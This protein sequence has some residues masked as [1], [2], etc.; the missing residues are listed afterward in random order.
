MTRAHVRLRAASVPLR[1]VEEVL[2]SAGSILDVGCGH[3]LLTLV[4]ALRCPQRTFL[5]VDVDEGKVLA[6]RAAARRLDVG[7]RVT[8]EVVPPTWLPEGRFDGLVAVDVLY[9]LGIRRATELLG[10]MGRAA[11]VGGTVAVKEMAD[12][13][14]WKVRLDRGQEL[15]ATRLARYTMGETSELVPLDA[16][17]GALA[18]AGVAAE[19]RRLDHGRLHPHA[20]VVGRRRASGVGG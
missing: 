9:L 14:A 18:D 13:P 8:F 19:V 17:R 6:A 20:L 15:V 1:A 7:D 4:A 2:P 3:G 11:A 5:G 10:A 12:G 16:V